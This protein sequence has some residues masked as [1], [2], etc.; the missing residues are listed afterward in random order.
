MNYTSQ[1]QGLTSLNPTNSVEAL[2]EPAG[3]ADRTR[4]A[5]TTELAVIP[6]PVITTATAARAPADTAYLAEDRESIGSAAVELKAED[7]MS[8]TAVELSIAD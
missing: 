6:M 3:R 4:T 7:T 1:G 5:R 2:E 8:I